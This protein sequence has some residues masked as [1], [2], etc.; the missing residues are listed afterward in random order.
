MKISRLFVLI[1]LIDSAVL[2]LLMYLFFQPVSYELY[3]GDN[4]QCRVPVNSEEL[5]FEE[6]GWHKH[7]F[8]EK[9]KLYISHYIFNGTFEEEVE[10]L[11]K[12]LKGAA[13]QQDVKVF[14]NGKFFL[15][16]KGKGWRRYVYLFSCEKEIFWVENMIPSSSLLIYKQVADQVVTTLKIRGRASDPA[17]PAAI[18]DIN[19]K[20]VNYTQSPSLFLWIMII[21]LSFT[22]LLLPAILLY[23]G[24]ATP[25]LDET[26][27]IRIERRV[28][29]VIRAPLKYKGTFC[30]VV[31]TLEGLALYYFKRPL[32]FI[33]RGEA[34]GISLVQKGMNTYLLVQAGDQSF[35]ISVADPH[36]WMNDIQAR[37]MV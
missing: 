26:T 28:Y 37:L 29:V 27:L 10:T 20:I 32:M 15:Y 4:F 33:P 17:L 1:I 23:F 6:Y 25:D 9:G 16:S 31:L 13:F 12:H 8:S 36:L 18:A 11:G 34:Q 14:D 7:Y 2:A 5:V 24:G 19:K 21:L 35:R 30:T 3:E 22:T